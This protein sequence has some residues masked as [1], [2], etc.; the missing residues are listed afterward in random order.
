MKRLIVRGSLVTCALFVTSC[1]SG[2]GGAAGDSARSAVDTGAPTSGAVA[3]VVP[4]PAAEPPAPQPPPAAGAARG[5]GDTAT[6]ARLEREARAIARTR[7]CSSASA[8]RSAPVGVKACG[9]PRTY[10][11]YCAT[12]TDTVALMRKLQELERAE[13]AYNEKSGMMSTCEFRIAPTTALVGGYCKERNRAN[14][15]P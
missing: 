8:C 5:A 12:S 7:G 10:I 13:K 3:S 14:E 9:G 6:I 4:M 2:A 11:V 15:V 1:A